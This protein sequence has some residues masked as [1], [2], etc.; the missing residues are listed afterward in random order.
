MARR[1]ASF[2]WH[3]PELLLAR[4]VAVTDRRIDGVHAQMDRAADYRFALGFLAANC[5]D[6]LVA[7]KLKI[8]NSWPVRSRFQAGMSLCVRGL[9]GSGFL[10]AVAKHVSQQTR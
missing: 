2:F 5:Q 6:R 1:S 4:P 8:P 9:S 10:A 3:R 7:P